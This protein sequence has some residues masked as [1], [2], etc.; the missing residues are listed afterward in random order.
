MKYKQDWPANIQARK[1]KKK[2]EAEEKKQEGERREQQLDK[3][4]NGESGDSERDDDEDKWRRDRGEG[5]KKHHAAYGKGQG[6]D[7][8]NGTMQ[9]GTDAPKKT[10]YQRLRERY[11]PEEITLPR[12]LEHESKYMHALDQNDDKRSSPIADAVRKALMKIDTADQFTPGNW[13]PRSGTL[14]RLTGQHPVNAEPELSALFEAGLITPNYLHY[15]R[16]HGAIPHLLWDT[17]ELDIE[18]G[19]MKLSM[20]ELEKRFDPVNIPDALACDG[21]RRGEL[22]LIK[23]SKG[24]TWGSGAVSCAY[25]KGCRLCDVLEAADVP[26]RSPDGKRLWVNFK[27]AD[28]L[29]DGKYAT[30]LPLDYAMDPNNDVLLAYEMNDVRLPPDHAYPVRLLIPGYVGGR[31][32]KWLPGSGFRKRRTTHTITSGTTEFFRHL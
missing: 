25:W 30:C 24:F 2:K 29:S 13:V 9:S 11:S 5:S 31:S 21:N 7:S 18:N 17:H 26:S 23:K 32:V 19:K 27:G 3:N 15:V 12:H 16:N 10:K 6:D 1:K 20:N 22:N 8:T 28:E 14:T 4:G